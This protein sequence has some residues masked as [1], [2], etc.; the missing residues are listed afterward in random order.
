LLSRADSGE[1]EKIGREE[2]G[3][4][5]LLWRPKNTIRLYEEKKEIGATR[6]GKI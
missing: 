2:R 5:L 1:R 4:R 3:K 6:L